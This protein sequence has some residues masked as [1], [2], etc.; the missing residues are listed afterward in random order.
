MFSCWRRCVRYYMN[1]ERA[2]AVLKSLLL[3]EGRAFNARDRPGAGALAYNTND[4]LCTHVA[5]QP[6]AHAL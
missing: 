3:H 5:P 6:L 4:M 1:F 2:M